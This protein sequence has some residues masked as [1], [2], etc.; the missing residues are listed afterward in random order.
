MVFSLEFGENPK[1]NR[2]N[3]LVINNIEIGT[4]T[5]DFK[6]HILNKEYFKKEW[7]M[8]FG[9]K[10]TMLYFLEKIK[11][12]ISIEIGTQYG[13]SLKPISDY[14]EHVYSFDLFHNNVN[15]LD[16]N[17][18]EFITGNSRKT[19]PIIIQ[20]LNQ[21]KKTLEFV[22]IDGDHSSEGVKNDI[23]NILKYKPQKPLY[24]LIHDSFNPSVRSGILEANWN[25]SPY[26][27][28]LD[29]DFI[30]GTIFQDI[31]Q[32]WEGLAFAVLLPEKRKFQLSVLES[33]KTLFNS[34]VKLY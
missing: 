13:G 7:Q 9:E 20:E 2:K 23:E 12:E 17:N 25:Q 3:N 18:V 30:H 19:V 21:S 32:L 26:V 15:K 1:E 31:L 8:N 16:F 28:F 24:I 6:K 33:Q 4:E 22:L 5:I 10:I 29:V 34:A 14:S 27:H 11:P